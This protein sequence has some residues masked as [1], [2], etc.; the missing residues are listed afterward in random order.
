MAEVVPLLQ[1]NPE[2]DFHKSGS[3]GI[4]IGAVQYNPT[5]IQTS[6]FPQNGF[7]GVVS[8][9]AQPPSPDVAISRQIWVTFKVKVT[10]ETTKR[11]AAGGTIP[12]SGFRY[13]I[14]NGLRFAP[15]SQCISVAT[16]QINDQQISYP[17]RELLNPFSRLNVTQEQLSK[18]CSGMPAVVDMVQD[19]QDV[20]YPLDACAGAYPQT[21]VINYNYGPL[22]DVIGGRA[23]TSPIDAP[24]R[25]S[26]KLN[27]IEEKDPATYGYAAEGGVTEFEFDTREPLWLPPFGANLTDDYS[28]INV[29]QFQVQLQLSEA[30]RML[31]KKSNHYGIQGVNKIAD[32]PLGPAWDP[33]ASADGDQTLWKVTAE[34]KNSPTL[35]VTW[36][37]PPSYIAIPDAVMYP[38]WK[39]DNYTQNAQWSF[40]NPNNAQEITGTAIQLNSV[41]SRI[42][43]VGRRVFDGINNQ[44]MMQSNTF[45]RIT[46]MNVQ[47]DNQPGIFASASEWQLFQTS[48]RRGFRGTFHDWQN[49]GSVMIMDLGANFPINKES[50]AVGLP[51]NKMLQVKATFLRNTING[52]VDEPTMFQMDVFI[53]NNGILT[54]VGLH[55]E[56]SSAVL[57]PDA[58]AKAHATGETM[59]GGKPPNMWGSGFMDKVK[60]GVKSLRKSGIISQTLNKV[61]NV[62]GLLGYNKLGQLAQDYG[63]ATKKAG[64]GRGGRQLSRSMLRKRIGMY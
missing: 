13:G 36:I 51:A 6:N 53:V 63:A 50:D 17:T 59:P 1:I 46:K 3:Y 35:E 29:N 41:P 10:V 48:A 18:Y 4:P 40:D 12:V 31:C 24:S 54:I 55:T 23:G 7:D 14:N 11:G 37:T 47:Y 43:V 32:T 19:Y 22:R 64:F 42:V 49:S 52:Y 44:S 57:T 2:L 30:V 28:I 27:Y 34:I 26:F 21:Q 9:T 38:Y 45:L 20:T 58:I 15:I 5:I 60:Q 16:V 39:V 25:G 62:A 8:W 56:V 33:Q 61:G